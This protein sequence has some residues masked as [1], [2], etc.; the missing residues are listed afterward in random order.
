MVAVR[1]RGNHNTFSELLEKRLLFSGVTFGTPTLY[2]SDSSLGI[3]IADVNGDSKPDIVAPESGAGGSSVDVYL[4][5]GDGTFGAAQNFSASAS[6]GL[7]ASQPYSVAV[8]DVTGDGNVDIITANFGGTMSILPGNGDGTFGAASVFSTGSESNGI[9]VT[10]LNGDSLPDIAVANRGTNS[11]SVFFNNFDH[12]FTTPVDFA[13][14]SEPIS[15]GSA[16]FNHDNLPDLFTANVGDNTVSVLLNTGDGTFATAVNPS[17]PGGPNDA[18]TGD[19]NGD[20]NPDIAVADVNSTS[21]SVILGNGSG[22]FS[23]PITSNIFSSGGP[24]SLATADFNGDDIPDIATIAF[25][26]DTVSV[27]L[28]NGDGSFQSPIIITPNLPGGDIVAGDFNGDGKA[29]IITGSY[30]PGGPSSQFATFINSGASTPIPPSPI[31]SIGALD[32]TFGTNGL[33]S[34]NVGFTSTA[35]VAVQSDFKSIIVGTIGSSPNQQIG[36]TRYNAD[37]SLDTTFGLNG[38]IAS[39]FG[40]SDQATAVLYLPATG[41]ILVAG[42]DTTDAGSQFVLAEYTSSG[43]LDASF[44]NGAGVV[45][46]SFSTTLGTQSTDTAKALAVA[47][48]GSTIYIAGSSNA[49]GRGLDF[50]VASYNPDGSV[51]TDFGGSGTAL[52]DFSGGDDSVNAIAVQT[53]GNIVAAGSSINPST[54]ISSIAMCRFLVSGAVD[55]HFGVKGKVLTTV[56]GVADL[57][58]S[59]AVDHTGKIVI[60]GLSASGSA[61]DGSL[62]S[63][64]VVARYTSSGAIDRSFGHGPVVTSFGQPSAVS[65]VLIQADG[66]IVASGKTVA[67]LI[68]LDPSQVEVAVARYTTKGILDTSFNTTGTAIISLSGSL[69]A[70]AIH[71]GS[72]SVSPLDAN[73]LLSEFTQF[74]QSSQG[75]VAVAMGGELL[76]VGNNGANTVE[77]A[78]VAAGVDLATSLIA[79][80]PVAALEGAK[81][82]LTVK[83]TESGAD[84]ASGMITIQLYASLDAML[85][86]GLTPFQSLVEK[87]NLKQNQSHTFTLHSLLPDSS[88]MFFIVASVDTGALAELNANNNAAPSG[89]AVTVAAPFVDLAGSALTF[90]GT[91][92]AGKATSIS[93]TVANNGNI[94]ARSVPVEVLASLDG[95]VASGTMLVQ[96]TV[97]LN[98]KAGQVRKYRLSLKIP[99]TLTANTYLFVAVLDPNNSLGDPTSANNLIAGTMQF[100]TA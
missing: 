93:F 79:K 88:G 86:T 67:S 89:S 6:D 38:V 5:Q 91:P 81:Q 23:A 61:A 21:F 12:I 7:S 29:D 39:G 27:S 68:N 52:F 49:A 53:N 64:F 36:L 34:H 20:G 43:A 66:K 82:L 76:D 97:Q 8:A 96:P 42:T 84:L 1:R 73:S 45:L 32:P 87:I 24:A 95:T 22:G 35:G 75:V 14:G 46:T 94:L 10:D 63:D 11:V 15:V 59:V 9:V 33:A 58:S 62:S 17:V 60:G 41:D 83:I 47:A 2:G 85:D 50:A 4:N 55:L 19:F 98:L 74:E 90:T 13:V 100:T 99:V 72:L 92:S 56:G 16:D 25:G 54:G 31:K 51:N 48:N 78:I 44:A 70:M 18:I 71:S 65:Q 30:S 28:G 3:A 26:A 40:G 69:M 80:L 77:A 57:A 37:G